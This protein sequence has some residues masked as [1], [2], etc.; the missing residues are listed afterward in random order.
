[1]IG[2]SCE[3]LSLGVVKWIIFEFI[4]VQKQ[5]ITEPIIESQIS[6]SDHS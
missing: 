6:F 5:S 4:L 3:C 1:M 2:L